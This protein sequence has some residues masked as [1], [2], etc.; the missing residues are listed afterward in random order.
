MAVSERSSDAFDRLGNVHLRDVTVVKAAISYGLQAVVELHS[1]EVHAP[2]E[3]V[4]LNPSE[5]WRRFKLR[6]PARVK[7]IA[8]DFLNAA[9]IREYDFF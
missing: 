8:F 1:S 5:R 9:S 3:C 4:R 7:R 6:Q 2:R